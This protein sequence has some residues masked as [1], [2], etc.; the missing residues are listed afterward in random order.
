MAKSWERIGLEIFEIFLK[1]DTESKSQYRTKIINN[2]KKV[3]FRLEKK[4]L[5]LKRCIF[6][7]TKK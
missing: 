1:F 3:K 7:K 5:K 4:I 2:R 6:L